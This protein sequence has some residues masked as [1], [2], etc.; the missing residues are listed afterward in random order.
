M[1][2]S[3]IVGSVLVAS[4]VGISA[5]QDPKLPNQ[6]KNS[7]DTELNILV[8]DLE[9]KQTQY[10]KENGT[11]WQGLRTQPSP[12]SKQEISNL[13]SKADNGKSW[14]D[15]EIQVPSLSRFS[16][17]IDVYDGPSGKGYVLIIQTEEDGKMYQK[18]INVGSETYRGRDWTYIPPL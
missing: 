4:V 12:P 2:K 9:Q 1:K 6:I 5:I 16:Y 3:L 13:G 7:G 11:Y 18:S 10:V 15:M 14:D 8:S 17:R